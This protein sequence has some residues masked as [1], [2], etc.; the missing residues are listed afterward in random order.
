RARYAALA[1]VVDV[2]EKD[3]T[4]VRVPL[5]L[6]R[7]RVVVDAYLA[8]AVRVGSQIRDGFGVSAIVATARCSNDAEQRKLPIT[9]SGHGRRSSNFH[10]VA[11]LVGLLARTF[12]L[13]RDEIAQLSTNTIIAWHISSRAFDPRRIF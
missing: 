5:H 1:V 13:W 2:R 6:V 3:R 12:A 10:T 9:K 7:V 4:C 11:T 8:V